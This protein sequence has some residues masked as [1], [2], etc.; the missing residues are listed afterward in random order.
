MLVHILRLNH[1][2]LGMI[3]H[4]FFLTKLLLNFLLFMED[5]R[6]I[7]MDTFIYQSRRGFH[8]NLLENLP[9]RISLSL[10]IYLL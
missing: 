9:E 2:I 10:L 8:L 1:L 4:K 7:H 5:L 6:N 3:V